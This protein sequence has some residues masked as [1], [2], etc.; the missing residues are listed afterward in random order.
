MDAV[1]ALRQALILNPDLVL[2][3]A[4]LAAAYL[5]APDGKDVGQAEELFT[6]V[7]ASLESGAVE[8]LEPLVHASLLVN[9]GVAELASG[10]ATS[11]EA[12]FA[13]AQD[14]FAGD[15][16]PVDAGSSVATAIRYNRGRMYATAADA[17]QRQ[18]AIAELEAYLA[19]ASPASNW[20]PLAYEQ[21]TKL[22]EDAGI[23]PKAADALRVAANTQYRLVTGIALPGGGTI[24]LNDPL[25]QLER[26][27][28]KGREQKIVKNSNVR[29]LQYPKLGLDLLAANRVVA[30]RLRGPK[31]PP[32]VIRASGPGGEAH[33]IRPGMTVAEL[34]ALLG[35]DADK[36][37]ERYGATQQVIYR[38]YSRLGF[39]VRIGGDKIVEI[40][41]AQIPVEAK[42]T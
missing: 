10:D 17:A 7:T 1:G 31:A 6:Q 34:D 40:I 11:A 30:I 5:V 3:K 16:A 32:L 15:D 25:P 4:N 12:L 36:W 33:E 22:C 2:A 18:S 24:T 41:V 23:E 19:E 8:D 37:D 39:G 35:G 26:S 20:W 38:F 9:A 21:Y 27:L 14:L 42:R 29:R 28:G 13:K